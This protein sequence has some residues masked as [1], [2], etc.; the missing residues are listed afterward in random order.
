LACAQ[1]SR[2]QS[3][4]GL[5]P[6]GP[7][8]AR[9]ERR[10]GPR[11]KRARRW[12]LHDQLTPR[13]SIARKPMRRRLPLV[14]GIGRIAGRRGRP[15]QRP[16]QVIADRGYDHD[17]YRQELW[18]RGVKPAIAPQS[19]ARASGVCG[20]LSSVRLPGCTTADIAVSRAGGIAA[21]VWVKWHGHTPNCRPEQGRREW[22]VHSDR[23]E[24]PMSVGGFSHRALPCVWRPMPV[25]DAPARLPGGEC[26][27]DVVMPG[28]RAASRPSPRRGRGADRRG[29]GR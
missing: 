16:N 12:G 14:D 10:R 21:L 19:T 23:C 22:I 13:A 5:N 7:G 6:A 9:G 24:Y 15:R 29:R 17:K 1:T 20:G 18:R 8:E 25:G 28:R 26:V 27:C 11:A 4:S 2:A 3:G